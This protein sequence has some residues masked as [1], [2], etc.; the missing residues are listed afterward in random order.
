MVTM[1][2]DVDHRLVR[3]PMMKNDEDIAQHGYDTPANRSTE[4]R[5]QGLQCAYLIWAS[6]DHIM[7]SVLELIETAFFFKL[8]TDLEL[9]ID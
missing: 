4:T 5:S 3:T 7:G 2:S 1:A 6:L 8:T 9:V